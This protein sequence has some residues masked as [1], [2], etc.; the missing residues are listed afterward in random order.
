M[1]KFRIRIVGGWCGN[2]MVMIRDHLAQLLL[3]RGY[4][5]KI[6]QQSIWENSAPP[7]Y[8]DLVLQLFS[9]FSEDE[10]PCPNVNIRPFA[11]DIDHRET[12][13]NILNALEALYPADG[14]PAITQDGLLAV[15]DQVG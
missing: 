1:K 11:Q 7:Q 3:D 15:S 5:V 4:Q 2:R 14:N 13:A 10:L 12:M 6:D 8:V 9:A